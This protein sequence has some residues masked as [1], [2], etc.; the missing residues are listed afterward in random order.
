MGGCVVGLGV[1]CCDA[2]HLSCAGAVAA[3]DTP[4][5][6]DAASQSLNIAPRAFCSPGILL[7]VA[8]RA[9]CS[10]LLTGLFAHRA[11]AFCSPGFFFL[12]TG[13]FLFAHRARAFCSPGPGIAHRAFCSPGI[14]HRA[15][16]SPGILLKG[17]AHRALLTGVVRR[18][19]ASTWCSDHKLQNCSTGMSFGHCSTSSILGITS[20]LGVV[21]VRCGCRRRMKLQTVHE[22]DADGA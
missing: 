21:R 17:I 1:W 11:F 12:L 18:P 5:R 13:L 19:R 22:P 16:C 2:I 20:G 7:T 3:A 14:A 8:H 6:A 4:P 9:F 15:F 10:P